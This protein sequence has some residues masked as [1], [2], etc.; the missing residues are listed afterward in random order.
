MASMAL[1]PYSPCSCGS[2]KKFKW[3]CAP[4]YDQ[5]EKAYQQEANKQHGA[6]ASI[7]QKLTEQHAKNPAVWCYYAE[8]LLVQGNAAEAEKAVDQALSLEATH[9]KA[10]YLKGSI[11]H[12]KNEVAEAVKYYRRAADACDPGAISVMADIHLAT[13]QCEL[14]KN[15]PLAAKAALEVAHRC[16][17]T[18]ESVRERL[19]HF[20][21]VESDFP[22]IIRKNHVFKKMIKRDALPLDVQQ[23]TQGG[24]LGKLHELMEGLVSRLSYDPAFFF[25]LGLT[26]AWVGEHRG[27]IEALDEYVRQV[28]DEKEAAEA[29]CLA[30]ALRLGVEEGQDQD[31]TLH[32]LTYHVADFHRFLDAVGQDKRIVEVQ[33]GQQA[34]MFRRLDR[35]LPAPSET[36]A[37]FELPRIQVRVM[38]IQNEVLVFSHDAEQMRQAKEE[39]ESLWGNTVELRN[40]FTKP[41][42]FNH[43]LDVIMSFRLPE[44][45][46]PEAST[47]LTTEMIR[48]YFEDQWAHKP[49][50]SL[51]GNTPLDAAA[52]PVLRRKVLGMIQLLGE[53]L[54]AHQVTL[55]YTMDDLRRKLGL[56]S[57]DG[58][59]VAPVAPASVAAMSAAEL[60]QLDLETLP[61]EDLRNAFT[62]AKRLDA[63]EL[64]TKMAQAIVT[65]AA[66]S[67]GQDVFLYDQHIIF[68]LLGEDRIER[69]YA[70]TLKAL[71]RDQKLN[72]GKRSTDY[73]KLRV[74]VLLAGKRLPE[75]R[76]DLDKLLT[77]RRD[78]LDLYVFAVEE[79]LR[80]GHK[81]PA[82]K[83]AVA[84]KVLAAQKGDR[85]RLGF[86]EEIAKRHGEGKA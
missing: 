64:A 76:L 57:A 59:T 22:T 12:E 30:E 66:N 10:L 37:T 77:E 3:C 33:Q 1:D 68:Q 72:A 46:P 6:A 26:R 54:A 50:R 27:A 80:F 65:R 38:L 61:D 29:W 39:I 35:D 79:L 60:A 42:S 41:A 74:K 34:V 13:A 73:R 49:F 84:G 71:D 52:H 44:G 48:S 9:A 85:D 7:L 43:V 19:N 62:T 15:H 56:I 23:A 75:A 78:D 2:G 4:F 81:E 51:Q 16:D 17:P 31:L 45:L 32:F 25:N 40:E 55:P 67:Q 5:V 70:S 8:I 36:L 83:F 21:G 28:G 18:N 58:A 20:F 86:F 82:A 24:K 47:R 69:A 63:N 11:A 14:I 53:I